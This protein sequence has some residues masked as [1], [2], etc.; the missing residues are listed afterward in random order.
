MK[1]LLIVFVMLIATLTLSAQ[2]M[3]IGLAGGV[4]HA[5]TSNDGGADRKFHPAY[6]IGGRLVYSFESS[7]GVSAD[8]KFSGEG[9]RSKGSGFDNRLRTNYIRIP[10]QGIYFFGKYGDRIRPKLSFGPSFGILVGGRG[11]VRYGA[12][13]VSEKAKENIKT[14]DFGLTAAAGGNVRVADATWLN[15]ELVYYH[16]LSDISKG[17]G[18]ASNRNIGINAGITFPLAT[19]RPEKISR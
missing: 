19:L 3:S 15:L 11:K 16:G 10:L 18:E 9:Q 14:F 7:W 5:W 6:N 2:N 4:A 1:K 8:V 12:L 13:E 17:T